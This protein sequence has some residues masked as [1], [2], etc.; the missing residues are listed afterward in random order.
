MTGRLEGKVAVVTGAASGMGAA[1]AALFVEEGATVVLTDVAEAAGSA[2]AASLGDRAEF[3]RHDVGDEAAWRDLVSSVESVHG[4]VDVL[5]NNAGV[6]LAGPIDGLSL[7]DFD[8]MV[9]V[10]QRGVLLGM[11]A[12]IGPMRRAGRG[13]IVN[14]A[15]GAALRGEVGLAAYSGT[16]FAVRGMTQVAAKELAPDGIRVNVVHPGCI[17]TPMHRLNPADRQAALIERI[18]M[19]RFGDPH[20]VAEMVLFLASDVSSYLTGADFAVDGGILL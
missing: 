4:G 3:H 14:I 1:E 18:P 11:R 10:N 2:L 6:S 16:K 12:V 5:V 15:S 9:R 19:R 13:S 17:D 8:V 7:D 20:E